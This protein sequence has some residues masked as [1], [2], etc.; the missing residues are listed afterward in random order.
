MGPATIPILIHAAIVFFL[1]WLVF[2]W[3]KG[4]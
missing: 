2:H 3:R 4:D 1:L